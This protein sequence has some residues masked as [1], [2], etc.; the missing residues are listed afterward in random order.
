[1]R[2]APSVLPLLLAGSACAHYGQKEGEQL[3]TELYAVSARL[4]TLESKLERIDETQSE[5]GQTLS[6][7]VAEV[8]DLNL[9]ARRNDA[10]FGVRLEDIMQTLA[11][12]EG[13]TALLD[14]R[15]SELESATSAVKS[16]SERPEVDDEGGSNGTAAPDGGGADVLNDP[17]AALDEARKTIDRGSP[18]QGR[19]L[20]RKLVR[21]Q[22]G[23][24]SFRRY[25]ARAQFLIAESYFA[26]G[27]YQ[28]AAAEYNAVRKKHPKSSFVTR[29]YLQVGR[30]FER[31]DLPADAKLFYRTLVKQYPRSEA[32][33]R[34]RERLQAL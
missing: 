12:L 14:E 28:Q 3:A 26:E 33:K 23:N 17:K 24:R 6:R 2:R 1:V 11:E 19:R 20:V 29:A 4:E 27:S 13:S 16:G 9:A 7:L 31:L 5:H 25:A 21:R 30:C 15:V 8:G 32:A 10:D 18:A 34:A 22:E